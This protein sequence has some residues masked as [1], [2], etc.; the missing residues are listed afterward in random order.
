MMKSKR[1][2]YKKT[3][4]EHYLLMVRNYRELYSIPDNCA[5]G[6][7]KDIFKNSPF[8]IIKAGD[9]YAVLTMVKEYNQDNFGETSRM[10][11]VKYL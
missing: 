2:S 5:E 3:Y 7:V 11:Q 8:N 4:W 1:K 10:G 9:M 6:T